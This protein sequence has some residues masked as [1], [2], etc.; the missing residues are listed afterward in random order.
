MFA[1]IV[2][3]RPFTSQARPGLPFAGESFELVVSRHPIEPWWHE[4][5]LVLMRGGS[6]F[7]QHVGPHSLRAIVYFLRVVPSIVPDFDG[8]KYR[9]RL[10]DLH[11]V[12]EHDGAFETTASRMLI[13]AVKK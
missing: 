13:E 8:A 1:H 10:L 4:I 12:I 7:A 5:A 6:Y 11:K 2:P 3:T 9:Q